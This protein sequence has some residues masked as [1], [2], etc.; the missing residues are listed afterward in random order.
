MRVQ[1]QPVVLNT[2]LFLTNAMCDDGIGERCRAGE[3]YAPA[4]KKFVN[5]CHVSLSVMR[6]IRHVLMP[7]QSRRN[8]PDARAGM[9]KF[10]MAWLGSCFKR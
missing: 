9:H 7:T 4:L 3:E 5:P 2:W 8:R 1:R 10:E 6:S